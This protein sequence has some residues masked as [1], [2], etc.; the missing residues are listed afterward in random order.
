MFFTKYIKNNIILNRIVIVLSN[1]GLIFLKVFNFYRK[2][3][4]TENIVV[5]ALQKLG[6][7]V[8]TIP[9]IKNIV[10]YYGE[11]IYIIC[12]PETEP[13]YR[14]VFNSVNFVNIEHSE[15]HFN[16]RIVGRRAKK[17]LRDI[18]PSTIYDLTGTITSATLLFMSS[19]KKIIGINEP[20]YRP[21][22]TNFRKV[23]SIP[24]LIDN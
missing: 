20:Y 14:I 21:I 11:N 13:I 7:S 1:T 23:R 22:Y 5:I 18:K 17:I 12:F 6:D 4:G 8:F 24:H 9:A 16:N 15:I 3:F 10:N 2:N 19:A